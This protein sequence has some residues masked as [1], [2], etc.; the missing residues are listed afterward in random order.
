MKHERTSLNS[1]HHAIMSSMVLKYKQNNNKRN[2][3]LSSNKREYILNT[4][5]TL[6]INIKF[7]LERGEILFPAIRSN[8]SG[9]QRAGF[10]YLRY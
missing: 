10:K 2:N 6:V 8:F 7:L 1:F 4:C 5:K 9:V 3:K